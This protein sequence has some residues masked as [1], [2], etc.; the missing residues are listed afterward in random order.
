MIKV[1]NVKNYSLRQT[2]DDRRQMKLR[3]NTHG[4]ELIIT[5]NYNHGNKLLDKRQN[6]RESRIS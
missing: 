6:L 5:W 3:S 4:C 2:D 1:Q